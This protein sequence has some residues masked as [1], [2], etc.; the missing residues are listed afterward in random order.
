MGLA[1]SQW[2][3]KWRRICPPDLCPEAPP[4]VLTL[5]ALGTGLSRGPPFNL[6][7]HYF[8]PSMYLAG[9]C[10]GRR[11]PR[12]CFEVVPETKLF[13]WTPAPLM[14]KGRETMLSVMRMGLSA[15]CGIFKKQISDEHKWKCF[16]AKL[17]KHHVVSLK[18]CNVINY[19]FPRIG[20]PGTWKLIPCCHLAT[21]TSFCYLMYLTE[22]IVSRINIASRSAQERELINKTEHVLV[23]C[24]YLAKAS[25]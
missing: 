6:S 8:P 25:P 2:W 24:V 10:F 17:H 20:E 12:V 14:G 13:I 19:L 11:P 15:E 1:G 7:S 16:S 9:P 5:K 21:L 23:L 4:S 18:V 3:T 22:G